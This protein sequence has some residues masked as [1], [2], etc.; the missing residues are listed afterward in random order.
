MLSPVIEKPSYIPNTIDPMKYCIFTSNYSF[1]D[2]DGYVALCCKNLKYKISPYNIKDYKLSEIW[3]SPEMTDVRRMLADGMEPYGCHKCFEP[4][5]NGVRSFRQKTL[6]MI[7]RG[8]PFEDTKIR[9]LDLRLGNICNLACIMCFAGNSN[10]I[11]QHLPKMANHFKW[12]EGRLERDLDKY[13]RRH[14]N[15]SDDPQAW[16]NI[17]SSID[18]NLRHLYLAGGEPFYLKNFPST[19]ERIWFAAPNAKIA[20]NTNGTRLLREKDLA[21]LRHIQGIK[22]RLSVD[23]WGPAEAYTRQDTVWEEKLEVMDQYYKEFGVQVWDITAN[24]LSVRHIPKLIEYLWEN[25][26]NSN[27]QVRPVINKYEL[28]MDN[29]PAHFK[30]ESLDFFIRNRDK[31]EGIDHVIHEMQKPHNEDENKRK[32]M[33][34]F[35]NYYDTHGVLTLESFD[36]ELAEWINT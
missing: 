12:K 25:Y 35:V 22:I 30:Q 36:P 14:Y 28:M 29:I 17:L 9:A 8:V 24:P 3:Q 18:S 1:I 10:R 26:P 6:G 4:E 7:N 5:R 20:I 31:L 2:N 13:H 15:W 19:V 32:S 27:V 21:K 33:K 23:G 16:E 34:R 11:Y